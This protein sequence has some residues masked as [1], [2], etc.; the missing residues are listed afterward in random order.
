[1]KEIR[2]SDNSNPNVVFELS[3]KYNLGIEI[4]SFHDPYIFKDK[5]ELKQEY[6]YLLKDFYNGKSLHAPFWDLNIG[7]KVDD[8]YNTTIKMYNLVY[9]TALELDC[10]DVIVHNGY[11]PNTYWELAWINRATERWRKFLL[12]RNNIKFFI[13]NQ[14][15]LNSSIIC[16]LIDEV[17]MENFKMCLDIGHAH[18]HSNESVLDWIKNC[19]NRIGYVHLHNNNGIL[20]EHNKI[21]QGTISIFDVL[22]SLELYAPNAIWCIETSESELESSYLLIRN[23][24]G[25]VNIFV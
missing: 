8:I 23:M 21:D 20:D 14:F 18:A 12:N 22:D 10:S 1:M 16:K 17:N 3:K 2:L 6:R 7:S 19:G 9:N 13:E 11:I 24:Y 25:S 15:E 4:Q 5:P